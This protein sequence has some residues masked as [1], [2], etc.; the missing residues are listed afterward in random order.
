M[1]DWIILATLILV[2]G[3]IIAFAFAYA[4]EGDGKDPKEDDH[5]DI[6]GI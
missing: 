4:K 1:N 6:L 3:V 2:A 5:D